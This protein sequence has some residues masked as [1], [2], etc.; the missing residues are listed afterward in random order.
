MMGS[1]EWETQP[2]ASLGSVQSDHYWEPARGPAHSSQGESDGLQSVPG[3]GPCLRCFQ[4]AY[5]TEGPW[6]LLRRWHYVELRRMSCR[7]GLGRL[8]YLRLCLEGSS[9]DAE[10]ECQGTLPALQC[11][12]ASQVLFKEH[13]VQV[14]LVKPHVP[15]T[16][17][18]LDR[19]TCRNRRR[20]SGSHRG[21]EGMGR[22]LLPQGRSPS[23]VPRR[24]LVGATNLIW[25]WSVSFA[26]GFD[27][28]HSWTPTWRNSDVQH[29]NPECRHHP[30]TCTPGWGQPE[31][32]GPGLPTCSRE[33]SEKS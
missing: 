4:G 33:R 30:N 23:S 2:T 11:I 24:F 17:A 10:P 16:H 29:M 26:H 19:L 7:G 3:L 15:S 32:S 27:A 12:W 6:R 21:C 8:P 9:C 14:L 1:L 22:G 18:Y 31:N 28:V 5:E 25:N 20:C 13:K